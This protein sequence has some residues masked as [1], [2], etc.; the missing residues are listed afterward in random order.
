MSKTCELFDEEDRVCGKPATQEVR[1]EDD[2]TEWVPCCEP[3][4]KDRLGNEPMIV[5]LETRPL[6]AQAPAPEPKHKCELEGDTDPCGRVAVME[7][8]FPEDFPG[9]WYKTCVECVDR[10]LKTF[11]MELREIKG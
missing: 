7:V 8:H 10:R 5:V 4:L 2:S 11:E 9:E 1:F 3:C 6:P